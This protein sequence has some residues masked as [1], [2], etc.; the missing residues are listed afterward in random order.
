MDGLEKT[1]LRGIASKAAEQA[2]VVLTRLRIVLAPTPYEP[3]ASF[4][5]ADYA[6]AGLVAAVGVVIAALGPLAFSHHVY[7]TS[8]GSYFSADPDRVLASMTDRWSEHNHRVS[9]HPIFSLLVFPPVRAMMLLGVPPLA[10]ATFLCA[11]CAAASAGLFYL[12]MRGLGLPRLF[13]A[14]LGAAY[15]ASAAFIFWNAFPETFSYSAATIVLAIFVLTSVSAKRQLAWIA[16]SAATLSMLVTNWAF[17]L[18]A[19]FLRLDAKA[20]LRAN[21]IA[22]GLIVA[23][24]LVQGALFPRAL[25]FFDP[26]P[27]W[28]SVTTETEVGMADEGLR[29]FTPLAN[30]RSSLLYSAVTPPT[31][32]EKGVGP[33]GAYAWVNNTYSPVSDMRWSGLAALAAWLALLGIGL[34]GCWLQKGRRPVAAAL[35]IGAGLQLALYSVYG[36]I[37]FLFSANLMPLLM[38]IAGFGWFTPARRI[39][40]VAALV[41]AISG[42]T[43]NYL[44]FRAS[45][46]Q[47]SDVSHWRADRVYI[48]HIPGLE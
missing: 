27:F 21:A 19:T 33:W 44:E 17:G 41:F 20:F 13:G 28:T 25:Y 34:W 3:A 37:P 43:N 6:L 9:A 47:S 30:F 11:L 8:L 32:I 2:F 15:C 35:L 29:A 46:R 4:A 45:A 31:R 16:A 14:L 39:A 10:G 36:E 7:V 12:A 1:G 24:S 40:G 38:A 22:F 26:R 5:G 42:G 48:T 18:L 23:L